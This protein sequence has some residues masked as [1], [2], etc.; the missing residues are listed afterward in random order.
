MRVLLLLALVLGSLSA[1][2]ER[3]APFEVRLRLEYEEG[4]SL[5]YEYHAEGAVTV[6]DT[7]EAS[8]RP[9]FP[10]RGA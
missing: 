8:G 2:G 5:L 6:P 4:D 7:A 10:T 3:G 1:C 9:A